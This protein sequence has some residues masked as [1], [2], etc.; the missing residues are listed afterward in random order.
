MIKKNN[1]TNPHGNYL[2]KHSIKE[3]HDKIFRAENKKGK[4]VQNQ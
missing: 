2:Y 1:I 4:T 3:K